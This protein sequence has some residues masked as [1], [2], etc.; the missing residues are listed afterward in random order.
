MVEFIT[1]ITMLQA[2]LPQLA[3]LCPVMR[4]ALSPT[5]SSSPVFCVS[6]QGRPA[7]YSPVTWVTTPRS[8]SSW[9]MSPKP[10]RN[11]QPFKIT[12]ETNAWKTYAGSLGQLVTWSGCY[13]VSRQ[14]RFVGENEPNFTGG[15]FEPLSIFFPKKL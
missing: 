8:L 15:E 11:W 1:C 7:K 3:S 2:K 5:P 12:F 13:S 10:S 9:R 6:N 14:I 4:S